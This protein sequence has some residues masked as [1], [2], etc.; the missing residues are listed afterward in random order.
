MLDKAIAPAARIGELLGLW[1]DRNRASA[2]VKEV[3]LQHVEE[4]EAKMHQL[5]EMADTL[6]HLAHNCHGDD[7][8][9]CPILHKLAEDKSGKPLVPPAPRKG[10]LLHSKL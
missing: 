10:E 7:R 2:D 6:R 3:A 4:L 1:R 8:P 9:D 5:Q